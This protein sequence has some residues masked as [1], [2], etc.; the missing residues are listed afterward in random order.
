ML[1]QILSVSI[2]ALSVLLALDTKKKSGKLCALQV[3]AGVLIAAVIS[4]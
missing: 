4:L 3:V 1:N 2:I